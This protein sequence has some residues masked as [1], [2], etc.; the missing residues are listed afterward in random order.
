MAIVPLNL[1]LYCVFG[2]TKV[3][4]FPLNDKEMICKTPKFTKEKE[5]H[6]ALEIS[7]TKNYFLH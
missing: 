7:D 5:M 2:S 1:A 4:G 6:L 3:L